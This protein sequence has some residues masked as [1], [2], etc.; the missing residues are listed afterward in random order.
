[1]ANKWNLH[2]DPRRPVHHRTKSPSAGRRPCDYP[3][4]SYRPITRVAGVIRH[5]YRRALRT[6]LTAIL[7][8]YAGWAVVLFTAALLLWQAGLLVV[9]LR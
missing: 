7:A 3:A 1:M 2:A 9:V 4:Y 6:V 8:V 5:P